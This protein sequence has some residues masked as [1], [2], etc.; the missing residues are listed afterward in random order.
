MILEVSF[1]IHFKSK[2]EAETTYISLLP[3]NVGIGRKVVLLMDVK[4]NV[5]S[6][7]IKGNEFNSVIHTIEDLLR[8]ISVALQLAE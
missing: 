1:K 8:C 6:I 7:L 2:K 4:N 5:L 3:D